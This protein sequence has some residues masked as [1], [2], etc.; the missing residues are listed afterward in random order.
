PG[1]FGPHPRGQL[2]RRHPVRTLA[3]EA[4]SFLMNAQV[5]TP[6][7]EAGHSPAAPPAASACLRVSGLTVRYQDFTAVRDVSLEIPEKQ[8]TALVGPSGC[9]KSSFLHSLNRLTDLVPGCRVTGSI[10]LA[11]G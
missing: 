7:S 9:G 3:A 5:V 11:N 8:I 1:A 4:P 10:Q 2:R 6:P